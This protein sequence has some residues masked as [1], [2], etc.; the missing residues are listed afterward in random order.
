MRKYILVFI[1]LTLASLLA[2]GDYVIGDGTS[3]QNKVP[4]YGYNNYGWSKFFYTSDELAAAGF[5]GTVSITRIA[6][7]LGDP[8]ANYVTDNQY[9]YFRYFYDSTYGSATDNYPGTANFTLVYQGSVTWDGPGWVEIILDTPYDYVCGDYWGLEILWENHDGSGIGGPPDFCYTST[10]PDYRAVYKHSNTAFPTSD[11]SR[12]RNR[13]N[14][15]FSSPPTEAP[16][17][18]ICGLPLNGETGVEVNS[19]LV[20]NSG[21]GDPDHYK[22][23]FGTDDPPSNILEGF[24]TSATTYVPTQ[25]LDYGTTYYWRVVPHNDFG[26]ALACPIWNFTTQEDPAITTFPWEENFDA[27]FTPDGWTDHTGGLIDPVNLGPDGSSVWEQDDWLNIVSTD[28]A[29]RFN[30]W[31]SISGWLI[32][33]LLLVSDDH[34]LTFDAA[35]LKYSQ[36]PDGTPPDQTGTDDRFAVL[37]GDGFSWST[38]NILREWNNS[39]SEYVLNDISVN[40]TTISIPLAGYSGHKRIAFFVGSTEANADNDFMINNVRVSSP[41]LEAPE[42][43]ISIDYVLNELTLSWD[44]VS[45]ANLYQIYKAATPDGDYSLLDSTAD[46]QYLLTPSDS[47]AFFR[48]VAVG[49]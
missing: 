47:R 24:E 12:T 11:G 33:P 1:L 29:A 16:P 14:I 28:K 39:G 30:I 13:P 5:S 44:A 10:D 46:L 20:W 42:V 15:W 34:V 32:S 3:T 40:G 9:V 17:P 8:L 43:G 18:A 7:Q 21:G 31:A 35:L 6:F 38:A 25:Y 2:A 19:A 4:L 36:P 23:W 37:I 27:S 45:G 22:I 48:V 41:G 49:P 26:Y